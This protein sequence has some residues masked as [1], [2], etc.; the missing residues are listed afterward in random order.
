MAAPS[1]AGIAVLGA[2]PAGLTAAHV[3]RLRA[4]G[5]RRVRGRQPGRR[6]REDGRARRLPLRPRRPPLLH[7]GAVGAG[8][9]GGDA[10]RRVPAPPAA[11]PDLLPR[12]LLR[13][14][15][16]RRGRRPPPRRR[17]VDPLPGSY[18]A[19][20]MR[21]AEPPQTFEDWVTRP[22]RPPALRRLLPD[23]HREGLGHP[24]QRDPGRVGGAADPEPLA[25]DGADVRAATQAAHTSR[26]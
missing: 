16:A 4:A 19:A 18:V 21:R 22:L 9:V 7:Q 26:A 6:D 13:L 23:V 24:R 20:K 10:R 3:L 17:R 1:S 5:R 11:L 8:A 15:A 2:G 12:R 25:L 14:P